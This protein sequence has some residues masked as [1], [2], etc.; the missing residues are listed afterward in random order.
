MDKKEK[1]IQKIKNAW[2][3]EYEQ[4]PNL[5]AKFETVQDYL[6]SRI[7]AADYGAQFDRNPDIQA[8]FRSPEVYI[9]YKEASGQGISEDNR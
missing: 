5:R 4:S 3:Q 6:K 8:E 9:A 1:L 7:Q 2:I